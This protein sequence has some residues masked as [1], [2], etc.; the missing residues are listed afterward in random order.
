[1][2]QKLFILEWLLAELPDLEELYWVHLPLLP[3]PLLQVHLLQA[4]P[5]SAERWSAEVRLL[6]LQKRSTAKN[7][8][9]VEL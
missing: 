8:A 7:K 2:R 9:K 5:L 1:M 4:L 3:L 6:K